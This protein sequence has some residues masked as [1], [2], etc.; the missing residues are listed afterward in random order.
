MIPL[1]QIEGKVF[2]HT[3]TFQPFVQLREG[4]LSNKNQLA[5]LRPGLEETTFKK[6]KIEF[7]RQHD[8]IPS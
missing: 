7:Q 2:L 1:S 4:D 3:W 8:G 6:E 5:D